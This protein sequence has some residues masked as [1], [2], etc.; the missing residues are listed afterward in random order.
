METESVV[1]NRESGVGATTNGDSSHQS[2]TPDSRPPT[3]TTVIAL[4]ALL[5]IV[6]IPLFP[7]FPSPNEL[8]RWALVAAVVEDH[9]IEVSRVARLLGPQF[10]DLAVIDGGQYSNKAPGAALVAAP[11]YLLARPFAGPPS[12][13]N[14]RAVVTAM[15]WFA[16]T[17]P[18][19]LMA[20]AFAGAAR[21]RGGDPTLAVT[22]MLFGSPLFAYGLLL[23]AHALTGAAL[24]GAWLLLY[25]RD[26]GGIAAGLLIGVAVASEYP[27]LAPALVL[28][29]GMVVQRAWG[30]LARVVAGGAPFAL[31]LAFYQKLAFG[32]VFASPYTY[33]KVGQYRAL[34]HTGVFGLQMPGIAILARLL[35]DPARGLLIF[36]PVIAVALVALPAA[37]RA[38]PRAAFVTMM[39]MPAALIAIYAGYPNWHGGWNV[40]PRYIVGAIP[41]LL[42]P[43]AFA[44][45]RI[46][47]AL[48]LGASA[49]AVVPVT[50]TFPFPDRSFIMPWSTLALP[51]LRHGLVAPNLLHLLAR[52]LAVAVPFAI[53]ATAIVVA[54]KRNAIVAALGVLLMFGAG[55]LAPAPTLTQRLRVGYIEEVYF[56]QPGAMRRAVGGLPLPQRAIVRA[57][58]ESTLPPTSWPF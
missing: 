47:T 41:F 15:R 53:V 33:E 44:R 28:V 49:A 26:R 18:L 23:F 19:L 11:G 1:G 52:S 25:L 42:F 58:D 55:A 39:L 51:L 7:H 36:A 40:G 10:E 5:A 2:P 14:L 32:S 22:A 48:L 3:S 37:R 46:V 54:T 12:A 56:E 8:T 6:V 50:L 16:A 35:F 24:F 30:R 21:E 20:F 43:L 13:S 27:S 29:G 57:R 38:L 45:D 34:A 9:S 31:L 4:Y 17:L